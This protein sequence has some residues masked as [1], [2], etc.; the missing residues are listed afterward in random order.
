LLKSVPTN[1]D[2]DLGSKLLEAEKVKTPDYITKRYK[3]ELNMVYEYEP[4]QFESGA[5]LELFND[6]IIDVR[7]FAKDKNSILVQGLKSLSIRDNAAT[8]W[9]QYY[10][11]R[12]LAFSKEFKDVHSFKFISDYLEVYKMDMVALPEQ[13]IIEWETYN[14]KEYELGECPIPG[15]TEFQFSNMEELILSYLK[16]K[17]PEKVLCSKEFN[18]QNQI[19]FNFMI[20]PY[21]KGVVD[22]GKSNSFFFSTD[23]DDKLFA[24]AYNPYV[25]C[26]L[27]MALHDKIPKLIDPRI[28]FPETKI[29][30]PDKIECIDSMG[31]KSLSLFKS[32][33]DFYEVVKEHPNS[34]LTRDETLDLFRQMEY[35]IYEWKRQ[36][37]LM[38]VR[39]A[40]DIPILISRVKLIEEQ[41][42]KEEQERKALIPLTAIQRERQI[43][44][45]PYFEEDFQGREEKDFDP[46]VI[47][48]DVFAV[49]DDELAMFN[50]DIPIPIEEPKVSVDTDTDSDDDSDPVFN[51]EEPD[52]DALIP[53]NFVQGPP[54]SD[55]SD[56]EEPQDDPFI[57][58]NDSDDS[59]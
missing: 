47:L 42:S 24:Y 52:Y 15:Y 18:E 54:L 29:Y 21:A 46:R 28:V 11:Q 41:K 49:T 53:G 38:D 20:C 26:S 14:I 39:S 25:M 5:V 17:E 45:E 27:Y 40:K 57:E 44:T 30:K 35:L 33:I 32:V 13:Y 16:Y 59:D 2:F 12:Q 7:Q 50:V 4:V 23:M 19:S 10:K 36:D 9:Y 55:H 37:I 3:K 22:D 34:S 6:D 51:T 1:F 58:S 31:Y 8:M 48:D 43:L 56:N